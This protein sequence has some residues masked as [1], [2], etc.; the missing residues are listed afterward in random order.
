MT[1]YFRI[2][3]VYVAKVK[4]AFDTGNLTKIYE[5]YWSYKDY[6]KKVRIMDLQDECKIDAE[7]R[8]VFPNA[9][10]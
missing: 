5:A 4:Q 7:F 10:N 9:E 8:K 2:G 6:I 1:L 3:S